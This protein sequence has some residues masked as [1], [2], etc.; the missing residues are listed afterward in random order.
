MSK[1]PMMKGE[2][3]FAQFDEHGV[4]PPVTPAVPA[5]GGRVKVALALSRQKAQAPPT[6]QVQT[7]SIGYTVASAEQQASLRALFIAAR[8]ELARQ[9]TA[10][11]EGGR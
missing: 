1:A 2:L 6:Y 8:E 7:L 4:A 10:Q 3:V 11:L 5:G 9:L